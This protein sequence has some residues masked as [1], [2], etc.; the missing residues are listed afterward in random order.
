MSTT[1]SSATSSASATPSPAQSSSAT[2]LALG[3][4][5]AV[6]GA[7]VFGGLAV[8]FVRRRYKRKRQ[9]QKEEEIS[10]HRR[11]YMVSVDPSHL[12][13]RVTPFGV[14]SPELEVPKFVHQP[15]QN[16]RVAF[17]RSDGGWE[18]T[19]N[20]TPAQSLDLTRDMTVYSRGPTKE[21]KL[22]AGELTTRGYVEPDVEGNPPPSY[23]HQETVFS[24]STEH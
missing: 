17:R 5:L 3:I 2:A 9:E 19:P 23:Y 21:T 10:S 16:M 12:A 6:V 8:Y 24:D 4:S 7:L 11:T 22:R 20:A 13:A 18:F 15:G 1:A 14:D